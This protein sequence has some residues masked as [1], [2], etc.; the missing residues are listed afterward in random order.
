MLGMARRPSIKDISP[1]MLAAAADA[2][3]NAVDARLDGV[4]QTSNEAH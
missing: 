4:G 2:G 3:E 1:E